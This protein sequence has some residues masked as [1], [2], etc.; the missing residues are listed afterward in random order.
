M[1]SAEQPPCRADGGNI[2][3]YLRQNCSK[4]AGN[5]YFPLGKGQKDGTRKKRAQCANA[6]VELCINQTEQQ[7][8]GLRG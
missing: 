3:I 2:G 5:V 4:D 1:Q 8:F 7:Q 6:L